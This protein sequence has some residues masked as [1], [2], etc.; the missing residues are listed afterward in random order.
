MKITDKYVFFWREYFSNW[1]FTENGLKVEVDG[2]EATVPTSEHLFCTSTSYISSPQ[3]N[4][5]AGKTD[6]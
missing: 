4:G 1:A 5:C 6:S 2:K 3:G